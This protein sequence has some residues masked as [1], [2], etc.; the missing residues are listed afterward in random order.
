MVTAFYVTIFALLGE[1]TAAEASILCVCFG[2]TMGAE[3]MNKMCIRDSCKCV[4]AVDGV[5]RH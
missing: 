2:L 5:L 1:A 3:L 4:Y